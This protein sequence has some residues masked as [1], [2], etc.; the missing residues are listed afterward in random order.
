MLAA[1][2][3]VTAM[4]Q[5]VRWLSEIGLKDVP[6]AED[7]P[8]ASLA[9]QQETCLQVRGIDRLLLGVPPMVRSDRATSGPLGGA[10]AALDVGRK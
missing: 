6:T 2:S 5:Y 1:A 7:L 8:E 3:A 4:N 9:G 10:N